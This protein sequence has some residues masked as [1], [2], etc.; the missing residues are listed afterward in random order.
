MGQTVCVSFGTMSGDWRVKGRVQFEFELADEV[1]APPK[2]KSLNR[3]FATVRPWVGR[4]APEPPQ[5]TMKTS[6]QISWR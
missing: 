6:R 5:T 2:L 4:T 3:F 1:L